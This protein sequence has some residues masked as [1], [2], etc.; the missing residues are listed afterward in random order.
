MS[1]ENPVVPTFP[2][3]R[4]AAVDPFGL[5]SASTASTATGLGLTALGGAGSTIAS[6]LG[7]SGASAKVLTA[8]L[9][10]QAVGHMSLSCAGLVLVGLGI[11]FNVMSLVVRRQLV[12]EYKNEYV[13]AKAASDAYRARVAE[14]QRAKAAEEQRAKQSGEQPPPPRY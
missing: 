4:A 6:A 9:S 14:E 10:L 3:P 8:G 7:L 11:V 2:P 13:A 12:Q 1:D 5:Q